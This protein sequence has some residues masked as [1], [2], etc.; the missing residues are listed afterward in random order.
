M[1][2][3]RCHIAHTDD[4]ETLYCALCE[5]DGHLAHTGKI[6]L[7]NYNTKEKALKVV[8]RGD[9]V[10]LK[11]EYDKIPYY[12]LCPLAFP[13]SISEIGELTSFPIASKYLYV[14]FAQE[15]RWKVYDRNGKWAD[16]TPEL[17]GRE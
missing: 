9:M 3:T 2:A 12:D 4:G 1:N 8:S 7:E 16:L 5:Q 6:L 17:W 10:C 15:G 14:Y 13:C 11:A